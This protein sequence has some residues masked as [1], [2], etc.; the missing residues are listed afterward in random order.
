MKQ[1]GNKVSSF[2]VFFYESSIL[3]LVTCT[4]TSW[5]WKHASPSGEKRDCPRLAAGGE[6]FATASLLAVRRLFHPA[7]EPLR[8]AHCSTASGKAQIMAQCAARQLRHE[9]QFRGATATRFVCV[10]D[11]T[12]VLQETWRLSLCDGSGA[13]T[14]SVWFVFCF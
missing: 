3:S 7:S 12:F 14:L 13:F 2:F 10:A 1:K 8:P 9:K 5:V 11:E 4:D 6:I